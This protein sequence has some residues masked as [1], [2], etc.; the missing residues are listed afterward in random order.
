M[1]NQ[2]I[3]KALFVF[4]GGLLIFLLIKPKLPNLKKIANG[5]SVPEDDPKKRT[6]MK[7]PVA[8]PKDLKGNKKVQNAVISLQAYVKAYNSGE[9]Q[10]ELDKLNEELKKEYGLRVYRR[11]IDNKLV[12]ADTSGKIIIENNG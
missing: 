4:G 6:P 5:G 3:K 1:E 10:S 12:V 8:N 11:G 9:P 2:S 7:E